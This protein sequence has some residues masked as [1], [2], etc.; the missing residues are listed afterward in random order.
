MALI[1]ATSVRIRVPVGDDDVVFVCRRPTGREISKFLSSRYVTKRNKMEPRLYEARL[2]FVN[3][4]LRDVE[5]ATF[6]NAAGDELPLNAAATLTAEDKALWSG[7]LGEPVE[8][9][10]DLIP[11]TWKSAVA[12]YFEDSTAGEDAGN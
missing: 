5:K 4:I 7:T 8:C 1:E 6:R 3:S 10:K 11:V 12:M 2:E 9:W